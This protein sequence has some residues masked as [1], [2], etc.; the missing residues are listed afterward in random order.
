M[1]TSVYLEP[2][3]SRGS[4][5]RWKTDS[6]LSSR[7]TAA[8]VVLGCGGTDSTLAMLLMLSLK[9]LATSAMEQVGLPLP[10]AATVA[11]WEEEEEEE[12]EGVVTK[13]EGSTCC[14]AEV[15]VGLGEGEKKGVWTAVVGEVEEGEEEVVVASPKW[16][17]F[18]EA[19]E[20]RSWMESRSCMLSSGDVTLVGGEGSQRNWTKS[21]SDGLDMLARLS[22]SMSPRMLSGSPRTEDES[23]MSGL[24]SGC[25]PSDEL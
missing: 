11:N 24:R 8:I 1:S 23:R 19:T 3:A 7:V 18:S 17:W 13:G 14:S 12:E 16:V 21:C 10:A 22:I 5:E 20:S 4:V 15:E 9:R 2:Q 25:I 6:K